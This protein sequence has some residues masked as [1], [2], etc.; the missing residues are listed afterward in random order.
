MVRQIA[1]CLLTRSH[2]LG[3]PIVTL[4]AAQSA[5]YGTAT[6]PQ[7]CR[8]VGAYLRKSVLCFPKDAIQGVPTPMYCL[9]TPKNYFA[10]KVPFLMVIGIT[11]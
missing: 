1:I 5:V 6:C 7:D 2:L 11:F 3:S 4:R 8:P 9:A 10:A